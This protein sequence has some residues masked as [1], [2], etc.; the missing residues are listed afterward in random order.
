MGFINLFYTFFKF[1]IP[2]T[3]STKYTTVVMILIDA[4]PLDAAGTDTI[5][6]ADTISAA[7]FA[8]KPRKKKNPHNAKSI[9]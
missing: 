6:G 8:P 4:N 9:S 5:A 2:K 3:K 1:I 7:L